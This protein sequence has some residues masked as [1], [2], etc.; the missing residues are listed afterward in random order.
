MSVGLSL[1]SYQHSFTFRYRNLTIQKVEIQTC[2]SWGFF[3]PGLGYVKGEYYRLFGSK[4]LI[5]I[6]IPFGE[7]K[8]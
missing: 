1:V 6:I 8:R 4:L 5:H 2:D 3:Q 7:K